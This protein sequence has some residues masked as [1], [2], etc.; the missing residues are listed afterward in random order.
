MAFENFQIVLFQFIAAG[1][2]ICLVS[3][4]TKIRQYSYYET[5][6]SECLRWMSNNVARDTLT[7]SL[8]MEA[9]AYK[10]IDALNMEKIHTD[11]NGAR[12]AESNGLSNLLSQHMLYIV[13][14]PNLS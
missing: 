1:H 10:G 3:K 13:C 6:C 8:C 9:S 4:R 7:D 12:T 11:Q 14:N 5:F 2:K